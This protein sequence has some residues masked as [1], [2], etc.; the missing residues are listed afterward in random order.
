MGPS[1][2]G[3]YRELTPAWLDFAALLKG[4]QPPL[5]LRFHPSA[6]LPEEFLDLLPANVRP[7]V[8]A[9][10]DPGLRQR[11]Q[12]RAVNQSLR[13]DLFLR[14]VASSTPVVW[15]SPLGPATGMTNRGHRAA[16]P[17]TSR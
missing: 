8:L 5:K 6:T 4:H 12:D 15:A 1:S 14:G 16:A 11:L 9:A 10:T 2:C 7:A 17:W 13:R 3:A